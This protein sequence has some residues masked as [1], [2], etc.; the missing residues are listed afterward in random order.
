MNRTKKNIVSLAAGFV[1]IAAMSPG[2]GAEAAK[3]DFSGKW[4]LDQ[5]SCRGGRM[6]AVTS[7]ELVIDH[8]EPK[9][10]IRKSMA[11]SQG[12]KSDAFYVILD[13]IEREEIPE[14]DPRKPAEN[15]GYSSMY[16]SQEEKTMIKAEWDGNRLVI[17]SLTESEDGPKSKKETWS[18]SADGKTLTIEVER[19]SEARGKDNWTEVY[20]KA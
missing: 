13:G 15:E 3:P 6:A 5:P 19:E 18:L 16:S 4:T 2:A 14:A 11:F 10:T 9:M 12:S 1:L 17:T 8:R 20:K 7:G